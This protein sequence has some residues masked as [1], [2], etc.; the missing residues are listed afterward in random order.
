MA[1]SLPQKCVLCVAASS[2]SQD[3]THPMVKCIQ[4]AINHMMVPKMIRL[5]P[6]QL[7][8]LV[9]LLTCIGGAPHDK[10]LVLQLPLQIT[11]GSMKGGIGNYRTVW[12]IADTDTYSLTLH[13]KAGVVT[14][15]KFNNENIDND[16]MQELPSL[17]AEH[18]LLAYNHNNLIP[19]SVIEGLPRADDAERQPGL[20]VHVEGIKII[21]AN[22]NVFHIAK[23]EQ[24]V[25]ALL[26]LVCS[27]ND[28]KKYA[29]TSLAQHMPQVKQVSKKVTK[30]IRQLLK[31]HAANLAP[32]PETNNRKKRKQAS[33]RSNSN[34]YSNKKHKTNNNNNNKNNIH[35][36][37]LQQ[38]CTHA[39]PIYMLQKRM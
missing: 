11:D 38:C 39:A 24:N 1:L 27:P 7:V 22:L 23:A 31:T 14:H 37:D 19:K 33:S 8:H 12:K 4:E 18:V 6:M 20:K 30:E 3:T 28:V 9:R 35:T 13:V 5:P 25:S 2:S 16:I 34:S 29:L 32:E 21:N 26:K 10:E 15:I 17:T 36:M